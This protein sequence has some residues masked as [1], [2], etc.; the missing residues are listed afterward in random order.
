MNILY[1][2]NYYDYLL[3]SLYDYLLLL[4]YAVESIQITK[5]LLTRQS[6][7][8]SLQVAKKLIQEDEDLIDEMQSKK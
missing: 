6:K 3:S 8:L 5:Y 4:F 7:F 1:K 2:L